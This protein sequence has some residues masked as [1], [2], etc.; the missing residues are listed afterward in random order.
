MKIST[1]LNFIKIGTQ[2]FLDMFNILFIFPFIDFVHE[3]VVCWGDRR[4]GKERKKE[5]REGKYFWNS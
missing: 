5:K 1:F 3:A 2:G 4:G